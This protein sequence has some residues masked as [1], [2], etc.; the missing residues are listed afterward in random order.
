MIDIAIAAAL[1]QFGSIPTAPGITIDVN[2]S[3]TRLQPR[4]VRTGKDRIEVAYEEPVDTIPMTVHDGTN[5]ILETTI[6]TISFEQPLALRN[7]R[8]GLVTVYPTVI[9][10]R[11]PTVVVK[12]SDSA[13]AAYEIDTP[14]EAA[15][16]DGG[17]CSP[18][19][20]VK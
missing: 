4:I 6:P 5:G 15:P 13:R 14:A 19:A 8:T 2:G 10:R 20:G 9:M 1:I 16:I 7:A 17:Q 11:A 18:K 3:P 12:G